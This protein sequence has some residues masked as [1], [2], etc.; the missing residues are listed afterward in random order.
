MFYPAFVCLFVRLFICLSV[1]LLLSSRKNYRWNL[2]ERGLPKMYLW[3]R[4]IPLILGYGN[5][6][7]GI[8]DLGN[9]GL[10][11]DGRILRSMPEGV[12]RS[13]FSYD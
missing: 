8:N 2:H 1:C 4:N 11:K 6:G 13:L 7:R 12:K 9:N 10:G 3:A 5:N